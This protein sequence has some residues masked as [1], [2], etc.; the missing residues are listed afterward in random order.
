M[1]VEPD[2]NP[3]KRWGANGAKDRSGSLPARAWAISLPVPTESPMP[4]PSWPE[5]CQSPGVRSSAQQAPEDALARGFDT[6][7]DAAKPRVWWHWMNGNV[8]KD[9]IAKD[10]AWIDGVVQREFAGKGRGAEYN[11]D[12]NFHGRKVLACW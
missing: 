8:T 10:F 6:P 7:P 9:G 5:A 4:A 1:V 2:W 3:P 12:E 11:D